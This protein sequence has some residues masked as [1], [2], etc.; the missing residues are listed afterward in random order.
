M[1]WF[2]GQEARG[3]WAPQ[4]GVK[5]VSPALEARGLTP[6]P[7]GESGICHCKRC[8]TPAFLEMVPFTPQKSWNS[9]VIKVIS[10]YRKCGKLQNSCFKSQCYT[11]AR[12]LLE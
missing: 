3:I 4:P 7:P 8:K 10:I 11:N 1:L 9:L 2:F 12:I 6:G 5:P